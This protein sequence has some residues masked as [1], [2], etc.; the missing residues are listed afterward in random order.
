MD[1]LEVCVAVDSEAV[2]SVAA[3]LSQYVHGGV[4]IEEDI[5][6]FSDREGYLVNADRP[7]TIRGYLPADTDDCGCSLASITKA[8]DCL[9]MI[10]PVGKPSVRRLAEED[11]ANAWKDHFHVLHIGSRTVIVPSWRAYLPEP[12]EVVISL[13]PGMAFGTGLHPT[14]RLC[15]E[16]LEELVRPGDRVLDLG[17]GSGILA[18]AAAR[19]GAGTVVALDT[20]GVAV[21]AAAA[22]V[23]ANGMS[24]AITVGQGSLSGDAVIYDLVVANI[25]ASVLRDLAVPLAGAVR[26]GGTLLACGIIQEREAEVAAA[27]ADAGLTLRERRTDGDWVALVCVRP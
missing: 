24:G 5:T 10:R 4:A 19:L 15:L 6:P 20:D 23:E 14:T 7:V 17:T 1:W 3:V 9:G 12:G 8:L 21:R 27:F 16:A 22:N 11:W 13:D 25:I 18:I 26:C 2:E